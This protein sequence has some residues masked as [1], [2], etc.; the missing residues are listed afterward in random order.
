MLGD[1][2]KVTL[3]GFEPVG[4]YYGGLGEQGTVYRD[5]VWRDVQ[6][7]SVAQDS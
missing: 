4:S 1:G 3:L 5:D 6:A 7:P 2:T